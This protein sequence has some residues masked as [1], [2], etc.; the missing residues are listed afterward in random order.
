[1]VDSAAVTIRRLAL[2][3]MVPLLAHAACT[4]ADSAMFNGS[5][6]TCEANLRDA[7]GHGPT[8]SEPPVTVGGNSVDQA[9]ENCAAKLAGAATAQDKAAAQQGITNTD[10]VPGCSC[11]AVTNIPTGSGSVPTAP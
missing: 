7:N 8:V 2:L 5:G 9:N 1:M 4:A 11:T 3:L 6:Y 10:Y